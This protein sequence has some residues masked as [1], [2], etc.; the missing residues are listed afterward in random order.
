LATLDHDGNTAIA[1]TPFPHGFWVD[2]LVTISGAQGTDGALYNGL[3]RITDV[4]DSCTFNY[5]LTD[6][7]GMPAVPGAPAV[8]AKFATYDR[9]GL[10][11]SQRR[12]GSLICVQRDSQYFAQATPSTYQKHG[13]AV[14]DWVFI[15]HAGHWNRN[16]PDYPDSALYNDAFRVTAVISG[17]PEKFDYLLPGNPQ[18]SSSDTDFVAGYF[19]RIHNTRHLIIEN[20]VIELAIRPGIGDYSRPIG[21]PMYGNNLLEPSYSLGQVVI[22]SN[23]I[24]NVNDALAPF[25][26]AIELGGCEEAIVERNILAVDR[27]PSFTHNTS[28]TVHTFNNLSQAGLLIESFS[29]DSPPLPATEFVRDALEDALMLAFLKGRRT[30]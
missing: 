29:F 26:R 10:V 11:T 19:G 20:N 24:R 18:M 27:I 28:G 22:R 15:G 5:M 9:G 3:K 12:L 14:G 23:V 4:P 7:S 21:I 30:E 13:L 2:D 25:N 1:I 8:G 16:D 6:S 17:S